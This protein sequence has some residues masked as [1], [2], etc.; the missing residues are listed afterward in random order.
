MIY[1][2]LENAN[3]KWERPLIKEGA[4]IAFISNSLIPLL[5]LKC[6]AKWQ[7]ILHR[8]L[9][10]QLIPLVSLTFFLQQIVITY[11]PQ[12]SPKGA[13]KFT[14]TFCLTGWPSQTGAYW[15]EVAQLW[16]IPLGK[17][18]DWHRRQSSQ[19]SGWVLTY[20]IVLRCCTTL[21][22]AKG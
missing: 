21:V 9:G 11:T 1:Q 4:D 5:A 16:R 18:L 10:L 8:R 2:L 17:T 3:W 13:A 7:S 15:W 12:C 19:K 14:Y 20:L 22:E 6:L